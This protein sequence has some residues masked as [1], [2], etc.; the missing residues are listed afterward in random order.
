LQ[1][2]SNLHKCREANT[3]SQSKA[4]LV[5][6]KLAAT[7]NLDYKAKPRPMTEVQKTREAA[8]EIVKLPKERHIQG[9][10]PKSTQHH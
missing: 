2:E 9:A 10:Q 7:S 8:Q 6:A 3:A 5:K 1:S 4:A